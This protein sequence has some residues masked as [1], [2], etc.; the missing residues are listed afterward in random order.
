[1]GEVYPALGLFAAVTLPLFEGLCDSI[2]L[3][4]IDVGWAVCRVKS[5]H[6]PNTALSKFFKKALEREGPYRNVAF[7]LAKAQRKRF[8]LQLVEAVLTNPK[9]LFASNGHVSTNLLY[10]ELSIV[11]RGDNIALPVSSFF[12]HLGQRVAH[13]QVILR[14]RNSSTILGY[15]SDVDD[16]ALSFVEMRSIIQNANVI[17]RN[18]NSLAGKAFDLFN[19]QN[20]RRWTGRVVAQAGAHRCSQGVQSDVSF[21]VREFHSASA[22]RIFES[23]SSAEVFTVNS[24]RC[25]PARSSLPSGSNSL[26]AEERPLA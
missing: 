11:S 26:L 19:C 5:W 20:V 17:Q 16:N 3:S 25:E 4:A 15:I 24:T 2:E 9:E 18:L 6:R 22:P 13:C 12:D 1:M 8:V 10:A 21:K 23:W 7:C 14:H